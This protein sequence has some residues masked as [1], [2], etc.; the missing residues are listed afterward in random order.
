MNRHSLT[1]LSKLILE[2]KDPQAK[3]I[4]EQSLEELIAR[5]LSVGNK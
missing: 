2:E 3:Y 4:L 5:Y 1:G